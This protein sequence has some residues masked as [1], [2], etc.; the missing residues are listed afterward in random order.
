VG[1]LGDGNTVGPEERQV[2]EAPVGIPPVE[3]RPDAG[4]KLLVALLG[5]AQKGG[6]QKLAVVGRVAR[7]NRRQYCDGVWPIVDD[8]EQ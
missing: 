3:C 5:C 8:V 2:L 4:C 7:C 1:K 6:A